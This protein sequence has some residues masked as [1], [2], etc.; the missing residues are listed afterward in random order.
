MAELLRQGSK[1][2]KGVGI[3]TAGR[4]SQ[5]GTGNYASY[6]YYGGRYNSN[7]VKRGVEGQERMSGALD[8]AEMKRIIQDESGDIRR[9]MVERYKVEF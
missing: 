2:A 7:Q 3:R 8:L 5:V 9:V 6:D 4:S 1:S